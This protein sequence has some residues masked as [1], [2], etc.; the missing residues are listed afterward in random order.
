MD[1]LDLVEICITSG[2]DLVAGEAPAGAFTLPD[3]P[4]VAVVPSPAEGTQVRPL[5]AGPGGGRQVG[6]P[7]AD[8]PALRGGGFGM[9]PIDRQAMAL[10]V[11]TLVAD[12]VSKQLLLGF[13]L[14]AGAIVPVIDGFFRLVIVWNRGVSFGLFGGDQALPPWLL[15]GVAI[16]VCI[17]LFL[18][19]RRTD[20]PLTGWGIGLVMGGAI[21][22]VI[23][24]ARWGA[25]FDFADFHI[26]R[27]HW[28]AFNVADAAIVVGVG[29]MLIDSLQSEKKSAP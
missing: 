1:G 2:G 15:S 25:V 19:L 7:S 10:L 26:G 9:R 6:R 18:W 5:L 27:W 14:K 16:A 29:L 17:G 24:R 11:V 22:N 8:L 28:P 12:Q 13:L 20:R 23:D 21:G 3:V 4:G